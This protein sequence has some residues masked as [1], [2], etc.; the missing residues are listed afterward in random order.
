MEGKKQTKMQLSSPSQFI[1]KSEHVSL[2][3]QF[4]EG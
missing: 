1:K 4:N 3:K 2:S